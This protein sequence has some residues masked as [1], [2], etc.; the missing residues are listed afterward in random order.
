MPQLRASRSAD[1]LATDGVRC[2]SLPITVQRVAPGTYT[3][4]VTPSAHS[5]AAWS[6]DAPMSP[7]ALIDTLVELGFHL[8]DIADALDSADSG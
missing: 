8:Q 4:S 2:Q 7:G 1:G 5:D 3:A 6:S